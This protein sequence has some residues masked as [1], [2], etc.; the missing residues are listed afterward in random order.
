MALWSLRMQLIR[1]NPQQARC[2]QRRCD[3]LVSTKP[4]CEDPPS[5]AVISQRGGVAQHDPAVAAM[6]P[7]HQPAALMMRAAEQQW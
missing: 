7:S 4:A 2:S 1:C 6:S 5:L 3:L